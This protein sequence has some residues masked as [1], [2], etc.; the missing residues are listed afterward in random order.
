MEPKIARWTM[1]GRFW[2]REGKEEG[3][4]EEGRRA[5]T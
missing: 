5:W 2:G 3:R 1:M 4:E